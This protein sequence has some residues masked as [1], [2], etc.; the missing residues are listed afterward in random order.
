MG[1]ADRTRRM[2]VT[3]SPLTQGIWRTFC[4]VPD[5]FSFISKNKKCDK[6][7]A[8][9]DEQA[10]ENYGQRLDFLLCHKTLVTGNAKKP[11]RAAMRKTE[12]KAKGMTSW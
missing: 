1:L 2:R 6:A 4:C 12:V 8:H 5:F 7:A 3:A 11:V 9:G 10:S